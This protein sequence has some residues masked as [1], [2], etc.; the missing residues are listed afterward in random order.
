MIPRKFVVFSV[1]LCLLILL[2]TTL[3]CNSKDTKT[4][5][6]T[7]DEKILS[8]CVCL[9]EGERPK[10]NFSTMS[11]KKLAALAD[12]LIDGQI[13][14]GAENGELR[15]AM[16]DLRPVSS[17]AFSQQYQLTS[18]ENLSGQAMEVDEKT[19]MEVT[20]DWFAGLNSVQNCDCRF[21]G[22]SC[23]SVSGDLQYLFPTALLTANL[24]RDTK[25]RD[26]NQQLK[27]IMLDLE[28]EKQGC[29]YNL[30]GGYRSQDGFL[31]LP[32]ASIKW[33]KA[34]LKPHID[35]LLTITGSAAIPYDIVGWGAVLRGGDG[36]S[37]HVHP[38]SMF[39][40]VYY[41]SVPPEVSLSGKS[42]GCLLFIDPRSG[43]GM[44]QI[45]RGRNLYGDAIEVC[46][47]AAG[48]LLVIFPSWLMH[49]IKPLLLNTTEPRVA[50][51]FNVVPSK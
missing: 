23:V 51:S 8:R 28:A 11:R 21:D 43:A 45:L 39:A 40:G 5:A 46:P 44:A 26:Y 13:V 35:R 37:P 33:L 50:I 12:R 36:Q 4:D 3:L 38:A 25:A 30:H 16:V 17:N 27:K 10:C 1:E 24:V 34:S 48:G 19:S 29:Q 47:G 14:C 2:F 7:A 22:M 42:N 31:E 41:V 32:K 20:N 6:V 18:K 15:A 49:E 9:S